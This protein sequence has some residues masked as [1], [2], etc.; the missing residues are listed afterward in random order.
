MKGGR[1]S[2]ASPPTELDLIMQRARMLPGP[3]DYSPERYGGDRKS[4]IFLK[5]ISTK[6]GVAAVHREFPEIF[7]SIS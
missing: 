6:Y 4:P 5:E 1:I 3:A 2:V 7:R